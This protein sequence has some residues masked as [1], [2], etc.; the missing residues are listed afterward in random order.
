M[1]STRVSSFV[2]R[3]GFTSVRDKSDVWVARRM[4]LPGFEGAAATRVI[5][6]PKDEVGGLNEQVSDS[7]EPFFLSPMN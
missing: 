7:T 4:E 2:I 3:F 5:K 1:Y 6:P